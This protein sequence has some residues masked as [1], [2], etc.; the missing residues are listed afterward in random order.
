MEGLFDAR[1]E[2]Q[3]ARWLA[4][5]VHCR[6]VVGDTSNAAAMAGRLTPFTN[7]PQR[8]GQPPRYACRTDGLAA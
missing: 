1:D 7:A 6:S 5:R 4:Q 3:A 8:A 2:P